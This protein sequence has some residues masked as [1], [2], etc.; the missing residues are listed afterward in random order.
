MTRVILVA[1]AALAGVI[2]GLQPAQAYEAPWCA[3]IEVARGSV[4]WDC[5]YRSFEDCYRRG[6]ILAGNRGFCNPSPY[7]VAGSAE[8]RQT[9]KRR[10]RPQ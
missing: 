2:V 7:Y 8:Q 1:T 5:Q 9:R 4:Y 10:A 6:N 3:V